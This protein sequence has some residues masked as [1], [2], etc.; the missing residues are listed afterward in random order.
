MRLKAKRSRER[1]E[2]RRASC[3]QPNKRSG[4][5][6]LS[7]HLPPLER[8]NHSS[9]L[10]ASVGRAKQTPSSKAKGTGSTRSE[11]FK[12]C[13]DNFQKLENK[14][15]PALNEGEVTCPNAPTAVSLLDFVLDFWE[16]GRGADTVQSKLRARPAASPY[17]SQIS[18]LAGEAPK[19][20]GCCEIRAQLQSGLQQLE[21]NS[22]MQKIGSSR[23]AHAGMLAP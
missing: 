2:L 19:R 17:S 7:Q 12:V 1:R 14:N 11:G 8:R 5:Y 23:K 20:K 22:H 4:L 10:R 9:Q 16:E 15:R 3:R 21:K 18:I 6:P 13:S